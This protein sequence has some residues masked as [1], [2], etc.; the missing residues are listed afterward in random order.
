MTLQS[1]TILDLTQF[2][3]YAVDSR[4]I[5]STSFEHSVNGLEVR[6]MRCSLTVPPYFRGKELE[7]EEG[8]QLHV[9]IPEGERFQA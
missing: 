7:G 5:Y 9:T 1:V 6:F 4:C 3:L 8:R 2:G